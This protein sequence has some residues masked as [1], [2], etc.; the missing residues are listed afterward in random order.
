MNR[1]KN[2][3]TSS[4]LADSQR[5][6]QAVFEQ[7]GVGIAIVA[8][9]G[10][11]LD[12]NPRLCEIIGY[13]AE[14]AQEITCRDITHAPD[15][16]AD[17][18]LVELLL[19]G[20]LQ[21]YSLEK[22]YLR[23]DGKPIWI[24]LN[25]ALVRDD[26]GAPAH[27]IHV[28]KD[29]DSRKKAERK[30]GLMDEQ[31]KNDRSFVNAVLDNAGAL[32][33]V[34]DREGRICRF[35]RACE[36][37]SQYTFAEVE[38][39]YPWDT[40][41]PP[42]DADVVRSN[43]FEAL[44]DNPQ[45]MADRYT[46]YWLSK[47]G[48]RHLIEWSNTLL[49]DAYGAM[50]FM[51]SIGTDVTERQRSDEALR[52]SEQRLREAEQLAHTGAW[53][54]D[55]I[56]N[57]AWWSDEQ[58][59]VNGITKSNEPLRQDAFL[60]LV[61]GGDQEMMRQAFADL[62]AHGS[63]EGDYRIV[64]PD[65]EVRHVHG[66]ARAIVDEA[67]RPI[68]LAGTNYDITERKC[69][70]AAIL[71]SAARLNDAQRIA[72]VGSWEL[73]LVSGELFWS[74]EIFRLFEIDPSVFGATYEA[75]LNLVHAEDRDCVN[76]A[77]TDSVAN[78]MPYEITHRLRM[79]DGRIKWVNECGETSYDDQG[80]ALRSVGTVQDVT[81]QKRM[82]AELHRHREHLEEM[83]QERTA[84]LRQAQRIGH[85]GNWTL[86]LA[87][88]GLTWS[89]EIFR[90]FGHQ[91]GAFSP[92]LERFMS[93][94]HPADVASVKQAIQE[95]CA[96]GL[97]HSIDHRIFLPDG[98]LRWV[99]ESGM[100][101]FDASGNPVSLSGTV[102]DITERKQV[103]QAMSEAKEAAEQANLAKSE[104]LSRMSHELR[105]PMNAIL[106]FSQLLKM[107]VLTP[108]QQDFVHQIH[109][110][111]DHLLELINELLDLARI[112][113]GK[114]PTALKVTPL[115]PLAEQ[116]AQLIRP[117]LQKSGLTLIN[118]CEPDVAVLADAT[119]LKQVLV[120]LLSNAAK[121]NRQGGS[122]IIGCHLLDGERMRLSVT[123]SGAGIAPENLGLLF[124][125]FERLGVSELTAIEGAGIGLAISKRLM[126]LMGGS[127]GVESTPGRG[128]TFWIELSLAHSAELAVAAAPTALPAV[129]Q[130]GFNVLYVEDNAANLK[131]VEAMLRHQPNLTLLSASNGEYGLELAQ[132]YRPDVILL[133]IHLPGMDGYAVLKE[134]QGRPETRDI[135]V[136]ALS[137]DAMPLD[138]ERG[139]AAGFK[140]YLTKPIKLE[141]L[142]KTIEQALHE[143]EQ[144]PEACHS[145]A[146][147]P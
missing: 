31:L 96:D 142:L 74:D 49:L 18:G 51:V 17:L 55:L 29:I 46:N 28:V 33:V 99:N 128:S 75:F 101:V 2:S 40:V 34:L 57:E 9:D 140:H 94:V 133:D 115:R 145:G 68:R 131:V 20:K 76:Q 102:Q 135:P 6:S 21:D 69:A 106:G 53:E 30:V 84:E 97:H 139:L 32:L 110:A 54:V 127:V 38:G 11:W 92:T 42:E 1:P 105:T 146:T 103:E 85:M 48:E 132:R 80:K 47:S 116:A 3:G 83:V 65:G 120:N 59:R 95:A 60:S 67:G 141:A 26:E 108:D 77:Y 138:V 109:R 130:D 62:F 64:R 41:L 137:A 81:E 39:Q 113:A 78:R 50:E 112:E 37:L 111:G 24:H 100:A 35:N 143:P 134:L 66:F 58:Y 117:L 56:S 63:F 87:S 104:F 8:P 16:D 19:A 121:Y 126:E 73:D 22:R 36:E 61:H 72:K 45:A 25:V 52:R 4:S 71:A 93:S 88:G 107:E 114:L 118:Q 5:R 86:N 10:Q 7:A 119:R 91:P 98:E 15:V 90:I 144:W 79:P 13:T 82:D 122:I 43:A 136:V 12:A 44:A 27:F 123:D 70:E 124:Q 14:E 129:S 147:T 89:D 125:P 23:K